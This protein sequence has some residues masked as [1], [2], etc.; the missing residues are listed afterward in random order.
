MDPAPTGD[1]DPA[2]AEAV[3]AYREAWDDYRAFLARPLQIEEVRLQ[4][5]LSKL[6]RRAKLTSDRRRATLARLDAYPALR[7]DIVRRH[8]S[9]AAFAAATASEDETDLGRDTEAALASYARSRREHVAELTRDVPR[10]ASYLSGVRL[11]DLTVPDGD[12]VF[13]RFAGS[14][15]RAAVRDALADLPAT[16][17]GTLR[18]EATAFELARSLLRGDRRAMV[19]GVLGEL[20]SEQGP[21]RGLTE[22]LPE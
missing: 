3:L 8:G 4:Q 18:D 11:G 13:A 5:R 19:V 20:R 15:A 21:L 9:V 2:L 1:M 14:R 7:D 10:S 12:G 16:L 6:A 17:P 22:A